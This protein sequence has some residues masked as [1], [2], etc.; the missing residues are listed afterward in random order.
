MRHNEEIKEEDESSFISESYTSVDPIEDDIPDVDE[1][2]NT[3]MTTQGEES[4][5]QIKKDQ[6]I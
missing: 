3:F 4:L 6:G 1:F 5:K 2:D